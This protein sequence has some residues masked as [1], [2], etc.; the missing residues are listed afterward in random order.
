ME[1]KVVRMPYVVAT[2]AQINKLVQAGHLPAERRHDVKAVELAHQKLIERTAEFF[3][4]INE[5]SR[6]DEKPPT[7]PAA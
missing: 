4:R 1:N 7:P 5:D 6:F 2:R 3:R